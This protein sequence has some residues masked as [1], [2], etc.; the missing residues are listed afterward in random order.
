[1]VELGHGASSLCTQEKKNPL[2]TGFE[3]ASSLADCD[4][5]LVVTAFDLSLSRAVGVC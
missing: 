3:E 5:S 1:M 2:E 4:D